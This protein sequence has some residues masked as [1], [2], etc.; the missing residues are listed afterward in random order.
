MR[1]DL[2]DGWDTATLEDLA[3]PIPSACTIG[4]FGSNLKVSDYRPCGVPLVFVREIRA[5]R[6]GG[7]YTK[8]VTEEKARELR[9]HMVRAGDLLVTKMGEPPGD[10]AVYPDDNPAAII[11]ADCIKLTP[12]PRATS[13]R[14][15][16][17][18]LRS[19]PIR[20][21]IVDQTMGVA[22]QKL[23]L[24]R[25]RSITV[26]LPPLAEQHRIVA[27]IEALLARAN[28]ARQRLAKVPALLKRFRQAVLAAACS[29]QLTVEW[30][31]RTD[32]SETGHQLAQRLIRQF[33]TKLYPETDYSEQIHDDLPE[34]WTRAA[35]GNITENC[36]G[37]RRPIK[38]D[39]RAKRQGTY[40]Y[41]GASGV[42]DTIDD[43]LFDGEFL[44]IGEDGANLLSRSTPIAFQAAGQFW[45]NNHAHVVR[46]F[47]EMPLRFLELFVNSIDL[48]EYVTGT[49]QPKMT[50]AALNRIPVPLPPLAEQH[51]IVRRVE[52]LLARADRIEKR[53]ATATRRV[54]TLT[55][56]ILAQAF[57][58][59]LVPTEAELARQEGRE[60]E[61]ASVL[62]ERIRT[63]QAAEK[64]A[65]KG[66]PR[67]RKGS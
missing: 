60:Y 39:D 63:A 27:K 46:P 3:A 55:Q 57:R 51:E 17:L 41:Y 24:G 30:R 42:I 65:R 16:R 52:A 34:T 49:A 36:D 37:Q 47:G 4:P 2:P 12:N 20:A 23:S 64:P 6:F 5:E 8:F 67:S 29:G 44:L 22:Q 61:P 62:L 43:Y 38:L 32:I 66:S 28:A 40:R 50:Q 15:L 18:W 21:Q 56:S 59:E 11:T 58:G 45:V 25:F 33:P 9:A 14:F 26:P 7:A 54:E 10:T 31:E 19:G 35:F 53:L 48:Q 13:S 1:D